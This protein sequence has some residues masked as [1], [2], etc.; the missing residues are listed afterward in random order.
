MSNAD[1]V[2]QRRIAA[3]DSEGNPTETAEQV[4]RRVANFIADVPHIPEEQKEKDAEIFYR[5]MSD[6]KFLPNSPTLVNAGRELGQLSACFVIP[7][8]DSI[9]G[10]FD[11]VKSAAKIHKSGGGTGFSF[12]RLRPANSQVSSTAGVASGPVSF[13]KVFDA[14]TEQIKQGGT[15]RGANMGILNIDHPDIK[16]FIT[17]KIDGDTLQNFNISVGITEQ[18]MMRLVSEE[19]EAVELF[20]MIVQAA[21]L[22]GDPGLFF[23]DR[24]NSGKANPVPAFGPVEST[25][26][27]GEQPLYPYD[28]CNLGS[29]NV[30]KYFDLSLQQKNGFAI[31][32]DALR[33]DVGHA[34]VFLDNVITK[35]KYPLPEIEE[36]SKQIR[37]VGLGVMGW[38]DLLIKMRIPY[39]SNQAL[40]VAE[41]LM[42][43]IQTAAD[44][45]SAGLGMLY[46]NFP[47][48]EGSIYSGKGPMRN[49]TRTT[50]APTGTISIIAECSSG[51][52]PLFGLIFTRSHYLDKN[53]P[54]KRTDLQELHPELGR[55][56]HDESKME[57][58][59][60]EEVIQTLM[61]GGWDD[62]LPEYLKTAMQIEPE[63]HVKHQAVFQK[64][65]DNA[66]SKTV[67][68]PNEATLKDVKDIYLYAYNAGCIGVTVYR[69]GCKENQVLKFKE[70]EVVPVL[71]V[72]GKKIEEEANGGRRKL[73]ATRSAVNHRFQVGEFEGYISVGYY[74]E[75]GRAGEIFIV[76]NKVGSTTR[77]YLDTIGSLISL[78]L[79]YGVPIDS[80]AR[81]LSG[82][83][84]EPSGLTSNSEI[85]VALSVVD[86]IG[87]YLLQT[88]K[89][90][91]DVGR[92]PNTENPTGFSI[93]SRSVTGNLC[94]ECDGFLYHAGGC[95]ECVQCGFS[96]CG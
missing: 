47:A 9:D 65:T 10:I 58:Y 79:Q 41:Y 90:A 31:D 87:R 85:P 91:N 53:D 78:G 14:A 39:A 57:P 25:N 76:G 2:I 35:N 28:S 30:S 84:F 70:K 45:A 11:A 8:P 4:F 46:G 37:R 61:H 56:L 64:Y 3:K 16:E 36:I 48:Y 26:P 92:F 73:P 27:C 94:P 54:S 81:K 6:G 49:S 71:E 43:N 96:R 12:N 19:E 67:N 89:L 7:V 34:I 72:V 44:V 1:V 80:I 32:I 20:D 18:F 38:H 40:N 15:R 51:I 52:E 5:L 68:L 93:P 86:Y 60:A 24:A 74:P 13:M 59:D 63:W 75:S 66:V 17:S 21:W 95:E 29:I 22:T 82:S 77:G 69:D 83:R 55:W 62:R 50:I 42:S 33:R 23:I 88:G